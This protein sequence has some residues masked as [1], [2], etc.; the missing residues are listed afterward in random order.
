MATF[1]DI[2]QEAE[3]ISYQVSYL[4]RAKQTLDEILAEENEKWYA[5]TVRTGD[6]SEMELYDVPKE[7]IKNLVT[8]YR[9]NKLAASIEA[10]KKEIADMASQIEY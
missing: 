9:I 7:V 2:R 5:L 8:E 6:G 1:S 10:G 4:T 3:R